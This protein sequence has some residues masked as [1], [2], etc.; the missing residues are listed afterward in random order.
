MEDAILDKTY[1]LPTYV[2]DSGF[3]IHLVHSHFKQLAIGA[4]DSALSDFE[5]QWEAEWCEKGMRGYSSPC[6]ISFNGGWNTRFD[7]N[8]RSRKGPNVFVAL[9]ADCASTELH[10]YDGP[11]GLGGGTIEHAVGERMFALVVHCE[12]GKRNAYYLYCRKSASSAQF[13]GL[14][15]V[16]EANNHVLRQ[17]AN[18]V[19]RT[20][21][22]DH[23][24]WGLPKT[25]IPGVARQVLHRTVEQ[26]EELFGQG[27]DFFQPSRKRRNKR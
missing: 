12:N 25:R 18:R 3:A 10:D 15:L 20:D 6:P 22:E 5:K 1:T 17:K 9:Y 27:K 8:M 13:D 24:W 23:Q 2:T 26:V 11:G 14:N 21:W 16:V 4:C 7:G 19:T